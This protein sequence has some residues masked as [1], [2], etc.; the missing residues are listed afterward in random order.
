[1]A[2]WLIEFIRYVPKCVIY[3]GSWFWVPN[4]SALPGFA[5]H[6]LWLGPWT[7][8]PAPWSYV[9]IGQTYSKNIPGIGST[10]YDTIVHGTVAD[11]IRYAD[12]TSAPDPQPSIS[13]GDDVPVVI[14][15]PDRPAA[16]LLPD[17]S[18]TAAMSSRQWTAINHVAQQGGAKI[19]PVS[20]SDYDAFRQNK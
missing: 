13:R 9:T 1:V 11:L 4:V 10:D 17:G 18:R 12:G 7:S 3:T 15:S 19:V 6:P 5:T 16:Y 8:A 2:N 14:R 20:T